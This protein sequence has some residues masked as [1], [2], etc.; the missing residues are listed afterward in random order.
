[1]EPEASWFGGNFLFDSRSKRPMSNARPMLLLL[2]LHVPMCLDGVVF[3]EAV[4]LPEGCGFILQIFI[5]LIFILLISPRISR[6]GWRG[7]TGIYTFSKL[8]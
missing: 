2:Q 8:G 6:A 4:D 7:I 1:M 5:L 3:E